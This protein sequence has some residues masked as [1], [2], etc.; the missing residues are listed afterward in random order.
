MGNKTKK[1]ISLLAATVMTG[2]ALAISAC[3][4]KPYGLGEPLSMP[5]EAAE[6]KSNGGFAV[7]KG[8]Y[9]YFINGQEFTTANNVYG[10]VN[11]G[12]LMRIS[13]QNLTSGNYDKAEVV[14][15][16]LFATS[17][18]DSGIFIQGDYVY[19]ATPTTDKDLDGNVMSYKLD[20]KRAKLDGT[21]VMSDYYFRTESNNV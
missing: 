11:K 10:D 1:F 16:L 2:S 9:V 4:P 5:A 20:F 19:F 18:T 7:E 8:G 21:E 13:T 14:V 3:S 12:S 15:P 17:N 6:V